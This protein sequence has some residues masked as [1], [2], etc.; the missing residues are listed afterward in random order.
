MRRPGFAA[1][2]ALALLGA[3]TSKVTESSY[4]LA[5]G[6]DVDL[7]ASPRG[8]DVAVLVH[9]EVGLDHDPPGRSGMSNLISR[10]LLTCAV[11]GKPARTR[12][13]L[14]RQ[15][16]SGWSAQAGSDYTAVAVVVPKAKLAE[17]LDDFAARM[18]ALQIGEADLER[19]RPALLEE[20]AKMRGGDAT[21]AAMNFAAE[22]I[23]PSRGGWR[24]GV[25]Q[26]LQTAPAAEVAAFWREHFTP[27]NARLVVVG[28]LDPDRV[29]AQLESAFGKLPAGTAPSLRPAAESRVTGTLVMGD[30]PSAV[31]L[32]VA[33]PAP[34]EPLFPAFLVLAARLH[35]VAPPR[36]WKASFAPLEHPEVLLVTGAVGPQER[37]DDAAGRIR[38]EVASLISAG[39][40]PG[41]LRA[42]A[43]S[44]GSTLRTEPLK[45]AACE[46]DPMGAAFAKARTAQLRIDGR[47]LAQSLE[48]VTAGQLADAA[49]TFEPQRTAAVVAGG[50]I[51]PP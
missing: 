17:A 41:E 18:G 7:V 8:E 26:E 3:C 22:A 29:R 11:P 48:A 40:A 27:A 42:A 31:A 13:D 25:P 33:A 43:A 19:E 28:P 45:P 44:Y 24:G 32:A 34:W 21:L 15:Y 2:L 23:R 6:L 5:N 47:A 49:K 4:S 36:S 50:A 10:L 9:Y 46:R 30:S 1:V 39:L 16:G 20:L 51:P 14:A 12:D 35:D 37:P 38:K